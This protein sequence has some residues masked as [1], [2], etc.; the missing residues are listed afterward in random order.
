VSEYYGLQRGDIYKVKEGRGQSNQ[1][2]KIAMYIAQH[3]GGHRLTDIA[4]AFGL[5]HYGGV[6]Y[7]NYMLKAEMKEDRRLSR[8]VNVIIN[9]LD[10]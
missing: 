9:G 4:H 8:T 6:S 5:S 3:I 2:R 1:P 7:A 10:P